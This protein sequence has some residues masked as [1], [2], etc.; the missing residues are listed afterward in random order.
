MLMSAIFVAKNSMLLLLVAWLLK[1]VSCDVDSF[2]NNRFAQLLFF[3]WSIFTESTFFLWNNMSFMK[4]EYDFVCCIDNSCDRNVDDTM[5]LDWISVS[6]IEREF[7]IIVL[8]LNC[9][10]FMRFRN[11]VISRLEIVLR[12]NDFAFVSFLDR[13]KSFLLKSSCDFLTRI[14]WHVFIEIIAR[15]VFDVFDVSIW[16]RDDHNRCFRIVFSDTIWM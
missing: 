10:A 8:I 14:F 5:Y 13:R 9:F 4:F 6:F 3:S 1:L 12:L 7:F 2:R 15:S 11:H 16:K